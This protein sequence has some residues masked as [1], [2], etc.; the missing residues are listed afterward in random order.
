MELN[1]IYGVLSMS[2]AHDLTLRCFS[3]DF[4]LGGQSFATYDQGMIS[5]R[6]KRD[7]QSE[8]YAIAFVQDRGSLPMHQTIGSNHLSPVHL[9]DALMSE[10]DPQDRNTWSKMADKLVA[11]SSFIRRSGSWRNADFL[12]VQLLNF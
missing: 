2:Q 6:L 10:A 11:D 4:Q 7:R 1:P 12:R 5:S 3:N 9:T 8:E